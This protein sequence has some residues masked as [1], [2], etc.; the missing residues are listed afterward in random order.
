KPPVWRRIQVPETYTF[1]ELHVAV[2]DAMGWTDC[3][4]HEFRLVNPSTGTEGYIGILDEE[5]PLLS[6]ETLAGRDQK[7]AEW[8]SMKNCKGYYLYDFGDGWEHT[9]ILEKTLPRDKDVKYPICVE[10]RRACPPEDCGST[11]GYE[12]IC[13]G[14]HECQEEYKDYD[15]EHFDPQEVYFDDPKERLKLRRDFM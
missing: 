9:V 4:L 7:I 1:W 11:P 2:Q 15:P 14:K 8:F 10:G 12:D 6:A 5:E 13:Q 3:H